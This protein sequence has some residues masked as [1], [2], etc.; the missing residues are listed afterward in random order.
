MAA[1]PLEGPRAA[2]AAAVSKLRSFTGE[3]GDPNMKA[4]QNSLEYLGLAYY[5][6]QEA[7]ENPVW[8]A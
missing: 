5:C 8:S 1:D 3:A 7:A 6:V 2:I 4:V